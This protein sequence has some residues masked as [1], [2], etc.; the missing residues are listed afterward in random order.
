MVTVSWFTLVSNVIVAYVFYCSQGKPLEIYR[1]YIYSLSS[2]HNVVICCS[3]KTYRFRKRTLCD[4]TENKSKMDIKSIKLSID[5]N[6][7]SPTKR[8]LQRSFS[9]GTRYPLVNEG[10][11]Q[12]CRISH[13]KSLLQK[14]IF[15]KPLRKWENHRIVLSD[16]HVTSCT[17]CSL[18]LLDLL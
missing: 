10:E 16:S 1:V 14:I 7:I 9:T 5:E 11:C 8:P 12:V 15:S 18:I 2:S 3:I 17:V 4:M 6:K 13:Q